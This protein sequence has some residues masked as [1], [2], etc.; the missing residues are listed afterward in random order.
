MNHFQF[1]WQYKNTLLYN[2]T[3]QF[4]SNL[5]SILIALFMLIRFIHIYYTNIKQLR[6]VSKL[7]KLT[8]IATEKR[9]QNI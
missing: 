8:K 5:Q 9:L 2:Y 6:I 3:F 1:N 4:G 7:V